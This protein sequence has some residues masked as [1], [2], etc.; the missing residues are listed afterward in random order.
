MQINTVLFS[1][2]C[3]ISFNY[4]GNKYYCVAVRRIPVECTQS[5]AYHKR[6]YYTM[7]CIH[8]WLGLRSRGAIIATYIH[9]ITVVT[10]TPKARSLSTDYVYTCIVSI[11]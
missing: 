11:L 8:Q 3:N 4:S 5:I 6:L 2:R 10:E 9:E 7:S 1:A